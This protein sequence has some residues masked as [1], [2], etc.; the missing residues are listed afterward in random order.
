LQD[1]WSELEIIA[2][3]LREN[4]EAGDDYAAMATA[5]AAADH[6]IPK[7]TRDRSVGAL[8]QF[9]GAMATALYKART[10]ETVPRETVN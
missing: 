8:H 1:V 7:D 5:V 4:A 3:W 10:G 9:I 6:V 2:R